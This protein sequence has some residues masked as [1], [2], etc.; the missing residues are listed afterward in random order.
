MR[1]YFTKI[2]AISVL[3]TIISLTSGFCFQGVVDQSVELNLVQVAVL[4]QHVMH[5]DDVC[6]MEHTVKPVQQTSHKT[7]H[8]KSVLPCCSDGGHQ[9]VLMVYSTIEHF[10]YLPASL[11]VFFAIVTRDATSFFAY[12]SP[13]ISPPELIALRTTILRI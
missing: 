3:V 1:K 4:E 2:I 8:Q 6:G 7:P 13:N 10:K 12:H 5:D 9:G 11:P